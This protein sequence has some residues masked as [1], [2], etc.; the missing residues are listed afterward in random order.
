[1][2]TDVKG[3]TDLASKLS[4]EELVEFLNEMCKRLICVCV[5][6]TITN[7]L[8]DVEFDRLALEY[9]A[10]KLEIIGDAFVCAGGMRGGP[11]L[12][13]AA[14]QMVTLALALVEAAQAIRVR[15]VVVVGC[16]WLLL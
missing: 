12:H 4:V 16:C 9:G 6:V 8:V 7:R 1:L 3:F 10:F 2:F 5:V 14:E 13:T 15:V 11:P